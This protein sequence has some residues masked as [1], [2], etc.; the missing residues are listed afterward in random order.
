[1]CVYRLRCSVGRKH[2]TKGGVCCISCFGSCWVCDAPIYNEDLHYVG[3]D[4]EGDAMRVCH[5]C[6]IAAGHGKGSPV[7]V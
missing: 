3:D 4:V 1:M 6:L 7:S 5:C 2:F